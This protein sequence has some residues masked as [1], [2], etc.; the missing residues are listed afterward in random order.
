MSKFDLH[1]PALTLSPASYLDP[2]S[3]R[4]LIVLV[5][6]SEADTASAARKIWELANALGSS[7]QFIG[8][9]KDAAHEPSLR[10]QIISMSAIVRDDNVSV[11]SQIELGSNWL[12]LVKSNLRKG[13]VIVCFAEHRTGF[14][15]RPLSEILESSLNATVYVLSGFQQYEAPHSKWLSNVTMWASS[16]GIIAGFFWAQAKLIQLPQDWA[17]TLLLY[18]SLFAEVGVLWM[19]N[20]LF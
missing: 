14:T 16:M 17:H 13:D 15:R 20:S 4:R 9:C 11:E 1:F 2:E 5:P 18:I 7:V 10:R 6:E 12:E 19:W 3:G 8:L